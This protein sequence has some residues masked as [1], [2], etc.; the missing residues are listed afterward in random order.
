MIWTVN[1]YLADVNL[2]KYRHEFGTPFTNL[3]YLIIRCDSYR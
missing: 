2:M 1:S 3:I